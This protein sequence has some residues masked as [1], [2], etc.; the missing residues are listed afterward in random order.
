MFSK[1]EN[2][3]IEIK[4]R[5]IKVK[6]TPLYEKHKALGAKLIDFG[7]WALPVQYTGIIDEHKQV[8]NVAGLF[9]VSHMGEITVKGEGTQDFLQLMMTNNIRKAADGQAVY[10][11]MCYPNGGVVD[12][13]LVYKRS[14]DD[15]LLVVNASNT[16]KDFDWL[17][18][19]CPDDVLLENVS[20]QYVQLAV[21][22]PKA[23]D[24]LQKI[25]NVDLKGI[26]FYH[27]K[28]E[29]SVGGVNS[30]VSRTGY[31]GEDGFEVYA[32]VENAEQLWDALLEAGEGELK[33]IGL[34]ARD[35]L[36]FE[37]ALPLYG[38]ELSADIT[39][40]EAGIGFFVK[41]DKGEFFGS[42]IIVDQ[43]VNGAKR[44]IVGFEM[45]ERGVPRNHYTVA[46]DGKEIGFVTSGSFSP[47]LNKTLGMALIDKEYAQPDTEIEIV[48][49]NKPVKAKVIKKPFY[50]KKYAK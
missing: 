37:V 9:D 20:S 7:G 38:H 26:K 23:Q 13:L 39:P 14:A 31:T 19:H 6:K 25:C 12:D 15:Y 34:G 50:N 17:K 49:R 41:L 47:S 3:N 42:N 33:P 29:V 22:G 8:R 44:K 35:T 1:I 11:P 45:V 46:K 48:I 36:R 30:L 21:Q 16:D 18:K 27:F 28:E 2:N 40:V 32:D 5:R 10:T 24:I 4:I 43:K